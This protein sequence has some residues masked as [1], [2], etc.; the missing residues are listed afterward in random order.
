ML[1]NLKNLFK[2]EDTILENAVKKTE[3]TITSVTPNANKTHQKSF[4][5]ER[6]E[7]L[8]GMSFEI[9]KE[10]K[11]KEK[12][13]FLQKQEL[14]KDRYID[15]YEKDVLG[16]TRK[17]EDE[18]RHKEIYPIEINFAYKPKKFFKTRQEAIMELMDYYKFDDFNIDCPVYL[19]SECHEG[20]KPMKAFDR[21]EAYCLIKALK[22]RPDLTTYK[23]SKKSVKN[24][25]DAIDREEK[26]VFKTKGIEWTKY[27]SQLMDEKL[28]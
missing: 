1:N 3:N 16:Y 10:I 27:E 24:I 23:L 15:Q 11:E 18:K 14:E 13:Y 12:L 6:K 26:E 17:E 22:E 20:L 19:D 2:K 9:K 25:Q 8:R 4:D 28:I 21:R 5:E 7:W